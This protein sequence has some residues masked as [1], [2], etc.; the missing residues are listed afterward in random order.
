MGGYEDRPLAGIGGWLTFFLIVIGVLSPLRIVV[1][2]VGLA[3]DSAT[4]ASFGETWPLVMSAAWLMTAA[5]LAIFALMFWRLVKV[6]TWKTVRLVIAGLWIAGLALPLAFNL[7]LSAIAALPIGFVL[8]LGAFDLIRN[9]VV[10]GLWTA[11]FLRSERVAN[12]YARPGEPDALAE[13]FD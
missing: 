6:Q 8:E 10:S 13:V 9:S 3:N 7:Y 5:Q 12:T 4:A 1:E 2:A 11:Y